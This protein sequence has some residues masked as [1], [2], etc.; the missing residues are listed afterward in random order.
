M[1]YVDP[2]M[3]AQIQKFV[4]LDTLNVQITVAFKMDLTLALL[5]LI[6]GSSYLVLMVLVL[7]QWKNAQLLL[8]APFLLKL[9]AQMALVK[10][11]N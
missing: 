2:Q 11:L 6:V 3:N 9:F 5:F 4:L 1:V 7:Y 8:L 10:I